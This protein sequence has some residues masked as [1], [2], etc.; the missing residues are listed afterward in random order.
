MRYNIPQVRLSYVNDFG[1][2]PPQKVTSSQ[3]AHRY[4]RETFEPDRIGHIEIFYVLLVNRHNKV[5]GVQKVSE[6]GVAGTVVDPKIVLQAALLAN[7]SG[8]ILAHNH[9]SGNM[10][11]SSQDIEITKKLRQGAKF[12]DISVND[13]LILVPDGD[14]FSFADNGLMY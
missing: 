1:G 14:Y 5:L 11:P 10:A 2:L 13:H 3:D 12:L 4:F 6:G 8:L 9:P 7:A